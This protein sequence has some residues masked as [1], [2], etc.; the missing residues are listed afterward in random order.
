[1]ATPAEEPPPPVAWQPF[2]FKGVAAFGSAGAG[3]TLLIACL[4]G[5]LAA[6][7]SA[8][9]LCRAWLPVVSSAVGN[10]PPRAEIRG[11]RLS[12]PTNASATL[13]ESAFLALRI[14]PTARLDPGQ[15]ADVQ[16]VF[17][18][19][20][21]EVSDLFG[22]ISIP[23]PSDYTFSL[24]R[25][26]VEPLWGA[27]MPYVVLALAIVV[28]L[29]LMLTWGILASLFAVPLRI[30]AWLLHKRTTLAGCWRLA[31]MALMPGAVLMSVALFLYARRQISLIQFFILVAAHFVL[32]L[33]YLT[34]APLRLAT[35][36][37]VTGDAGQQTPAA[38]PTVRSTV[39]PTGTRSDA[40][41]AAATADGS[42]EKPEPPTSV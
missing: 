7:A 36:P 24:S 23:Y 8:Y 15:S 39:L 4:I 11:E 29:G 20:T 2:T 32:H 28:W 12:W 40:G 37:D 30:L 19:S 9:F 22:A 21:L 33:T 1:V 34:I 14:N 35:R 31:I 13:G 10:L 18:R 25:S 41:Q 6:A 38:G 5:C 17:T 26:E 27:W 16:V 3:G 42:P